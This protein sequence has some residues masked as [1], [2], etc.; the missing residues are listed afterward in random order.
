MYGTHKQNSQVTE[1]QHPEA[2]VVSTE[3]WKPWT[4]VKFGSIVLWPRKAT[5]IDSALQRVT[6]VNDR[7]NCL[8][9]GNSC[10]YTLE[11]RCHTEDF[12]KRLGLQPFIWNMTNNSNLNT[13]GLHYVQGD[14]NVSVYL[15][16][17]IQNVTSNVQSFP[18]QSPDIYWHAELCSR[19]PC[20]A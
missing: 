20:S 7:K 10:T 17:T 18:R 11:I 3:Q 8:A 14:Q 4:G 2:S 9:C 12:L 15:I 6:H 5:R 16:I 13:S 19:G 1:L